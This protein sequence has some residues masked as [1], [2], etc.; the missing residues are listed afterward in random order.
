MWVS[1][2]LE[3]CAALNLQNGRC[4]KRHVRN[5]A[6]V[7]AMLFVVLAVPR[8]ALG[9]V[10]VTWPATVNVAPY[11]SVTFIQPDQGR[12]PRVPPPAAPDTLTI[13]SQSDQTVAA[14]YDGAT[15]T[16]D[17]PAGYTLVIIIGCG[18]V[19][20]NP[21]SC[22]ATACGQLCYGPIAMPR[23]DVYFTTFAP[24]VPV[25]PPD[26]RSLTVTYPAGWNLI[27][28]IAGT[29]GRVTRLT[30]ARGPI[31]TLPSGDT[32]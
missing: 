2:R 28:G 21:I 19:A 20:G 3:L 17:A 29:Y 30:S 23:D 13:Y 12:D 1:S 16:L 22:P 10:P 26:V 9:S 4:T 18:A 31:Y 8:A 14:T 11:G 7:V 5:L 27:A 25:T 32:Q 15:L 6:A 24:G